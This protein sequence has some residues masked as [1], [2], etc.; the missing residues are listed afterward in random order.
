MVKAATTA[1]R[2]KVS[3]LLPTPS[4][5]RSEQRF[6]SHGAGRSRKHGRSHRP[7]ASVRRRRGV[8]CLSICS[9]KSLEAHG[10]A[11][12]ADARSRRP[13]P[14]QCGAEAHW[15]IGSGHLQ[16]SFRLGECAPAFDRN[17]DHRCRDVAPDADSK[18][19]VL[20][21]ETIAGAYR[22][23]SEHSWG[24][25]WNPHAAS[26]SSARLG[27]RPQRPASS[28]SRPSRQPPG[29]GEPVLAA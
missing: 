10:Q 15:E 20:V 4:A 26:T 9:P 28:A 13:A 2:R 27:V 22:F 1:A 11:I 7:S 6:I 8:D 19:S 16:H 25:I 23:L 12:A 17:S 5:M 3:W 29:P 21:S 14:G 24:G 18:S